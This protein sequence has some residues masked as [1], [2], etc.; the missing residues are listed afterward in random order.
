MFL[1]LRPKLKFRMRQNAL[2]F[3]LCFLFSAPLFSQNKNA[4]DK[5][6]ISGTIKDGKTG[7]ELIG[8]TIFLKDSA[9]IGTV[10][11]AYGFYSLTIPSSKREVVVRYVGYNDFAVT[12]DSLK[13]QSID[14]SLSPA[15]KTLKEVE[16]KATKSNDNI[17]TA[18]VSAIKLDIKQLE[19]IPVLFGE[20]DILKTIQL[21]PGVQ[22]ASE[23]NS[24]FYVR[25]SSNDQNLVLL[26]EHANNLALKKNLR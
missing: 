6:T 10:T 26:D 4:T 16:I 15:S 20:K 18:E 17:T 13:S 21:L 24:G 25:G 19:K 5:F 1:L 14:V 23:G 12:L 9:G 7:E 22:P 8:A 2:W 11:N 3:A